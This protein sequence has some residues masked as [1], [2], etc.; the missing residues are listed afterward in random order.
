[1]VTD[2]DKARQAVT[3]GTFG[4]GGAW[5]T[6]FWIDP[7]EKMVMVFMTQIT[8]YSH[9]NIRQDFPNMVMQAITESYR[10]GPGQIRGYE[11]I[12]R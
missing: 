4:W 2:A 9:F 5:G 3:P 12:P 10:S 11:P 1:M 7:A 8:S 6:V